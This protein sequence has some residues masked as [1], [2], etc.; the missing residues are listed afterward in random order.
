MMDKGNTE[1]ALVSAKDCRI[2]KAPDE[3]GYVYDLEVGD[4]SHTFFANGI[5]VH[6]SI[7]VR[8]D[9]ILKLLSKE[10]GDNSRRCRY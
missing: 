3:D 9:N 4:D 8:M 10:Y 1:Y 6:N 5:L 7:Y 2:E